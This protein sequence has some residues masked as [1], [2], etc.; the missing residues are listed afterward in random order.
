MAGAERCPFCQTRI[1]IGANFCPGCSRPAAEIAAQ[2]SA[3]PTD[4]TMVAAGNRL[5]LWLIKGLLAVVLI[6]S[7]FWLWAMIAAWSSVAVAWAV[8]AVV[9]FAGYGFVKH[10]P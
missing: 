3:Q 4:S 9:A 7:L 5:S 1:P 10:K 2:R 8:I 6:V